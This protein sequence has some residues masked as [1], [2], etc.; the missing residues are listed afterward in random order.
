MQGQADPSNQGQSDQG[1]C[2][3]K[4]GQT[5]R[6]PDLDPIVS[7]PQTQTCSWSLDIRSSEHPNYTELFNMAWASL[8]HVC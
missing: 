4:Y 8:V 1:W 5:G 3:F 7:Q 6:D 2:L